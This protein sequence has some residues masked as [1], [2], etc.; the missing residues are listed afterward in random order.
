VRPV[1]TGGPVVELE[2]S[3]V[4][5]LEPVEPVEAVEAVESEPAADTAPERSAESQPWRRT[6]MAALTDL[7]TDSDD[8]TPRRRR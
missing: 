1:R 8:L 7:A 2:A 6:A 5:E 3:L 4:R